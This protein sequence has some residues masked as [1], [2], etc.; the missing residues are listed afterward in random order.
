M[1]KKKNSSFEK[2]TGQSL[3]QLCDV[4]RGLGSYKKE[5]EEINVL[6]SQLLLDILNLMIIPSSQTEEFL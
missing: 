6:M 4:E 1:E 5:T 3:N 2:K